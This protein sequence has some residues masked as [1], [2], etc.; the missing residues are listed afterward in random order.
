[1]KTMTLRSTA[2]RCALEISPKCSGF[3]IPTK[4]SPD[5]CLLCERMG[6]SERMKSTYTCDYSQK[7]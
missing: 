6:T 7:V 4:E 5:N 3:F 1:M 2:E